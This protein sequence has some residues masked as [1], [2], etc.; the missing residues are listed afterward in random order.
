[1][2]AVDLDFGVVGERGECER[3]R[4][5][6]REDAEV[7]DALLLGAVNRRRDE[8]DGGLEADGDED[9]FLVRLLDRQRKRVERGVDD[10]DV[11]TVGLLARQ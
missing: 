2:N 9:D 5:V 7:G 8:R 3:H 1:M 11:A 10:S 6:R 4:L